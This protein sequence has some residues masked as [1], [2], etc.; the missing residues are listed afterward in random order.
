MHYEWT[1]KALKAGKHVLLEKPA[2]SNAEEARDLFRHPILKSPNAP[3]LLEARHYQFHPAWSIFLSLFDPKDVEEASARAALPSGMFPIGDIRFQYHLAGGTLLDLGTYTLSALR[4]IFHA[5]PTAVTS[6]TPRLMPA[7]HDQ[8]CDHAMQATYAFPNGGVGT[9]FCDLGSKVKYEKDKGSWWAWWFK[10]WPDFTTDMPPWISVRLREE[11]D[12]LEPP[13][14]TTQKTIVMNNFMGPHLYHKIQIDTTTIHRDAAG[15]VTKRETN[16]EVKKAY[17]W[18]EGQG[19]ETKGEEFWP[20][21]RL[22]W[23]RLWIASRAGRGVVCGWMVK[24]LS[25]RWRLLIRRTRQR[26][27]CLGQRVR[28]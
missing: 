15:N 19:G 9:M 22:C 17:V 6:A 23:R 21:Y 20:T 28:H 11:G 16:T 8:K 18:P 27:W 14:F 10:G 4:G 7:T 26:V 1:I 24:N 13:G 12:V 3:V 2:T 25:G 5:E